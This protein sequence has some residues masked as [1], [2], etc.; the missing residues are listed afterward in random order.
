MI[1]GAAPPHIADLCVNKHDLPVIRIKTYEVR[2]FTA[3]VIT[4]PDRYGFNFGGKFV[5]R[6]PVG[7]ALA[8]AC[9]RKSPKMDCLYQCARFAA[10]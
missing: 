7:S 4:Q 1:S 9:Y 6:D 2:G 3:I 10:Y 5:I 8:F